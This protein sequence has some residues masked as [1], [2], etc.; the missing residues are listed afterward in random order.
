M[1]TGMLFTK[2]LALF[3]MFGNVATVLLL[4]VAIVH[5]PFYNRVMN[6]LERHAVLIAFLLSFFSTI[7]SII[8]SEILG[9]SACILCWIQRIFMYPL[10]FLFG[11]ALWRKEASI[12]PYAFLL[13]LVGGLVA[14][15]QWAKDMLAL[16]G[17]TV[18]PCPAVS[19]LPSC[20]KILVLENG[21][22]TI[23]MIALNAFVL[24]CIVLYA[25]MRTRHNDH[26]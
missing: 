19:S 17:D 26:E 10:M 25:G 15:Y 12:M 2:V 24:I 5:T 14:L 11:L 8:Y 20:D 7:G 16:Y 22:I 23:P 21:Y 3:T 1:D 13:A 18:I 4:V 9:F 6:I